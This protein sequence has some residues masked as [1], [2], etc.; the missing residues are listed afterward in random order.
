MRADGDHAGP[1][2]LGE[3]LQRFAGLAVALLGLGVGTA[4][5]LLGSGFAAA[6]LPAGARGRA[7]CACGARRACARGQPPGA[8]PR[9][10][11]PRARRSV[12][13]RAGRVRRRRGSRAPRRAGGRRRRPPRPTLAGSMPPIANKGSVACAAAWRDQLEAGG[14]AALLGRRLPDRPDADVVARPARP[15]RRLDLLGGVGGEADRSRRGRGPRAPPRRRCRPGRRGRRRRRTRRRQVGVVVDD[16]QGAVG[17]GE[18][19]EGAAARSISRLRQLASRAA[20][21]CRRRRRARRAAAARGPR[22]PAAR[23]RR[24]RG[25]R[26]AAARGAAAPM[27]SGGA[28]LMRPRFVLAAS[29]DHRGPRRGY[30][31]APVRRA[32]EYDR[33]NGSPP[34]AERAA[35]APPTV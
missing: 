7:A 6:P 32:T 1:L 16:E 17:V 5:A 31:A 8:P 14:R 23:R 20:G 4:H 22:R 18:P 27:P 13:R 3:R 9:R 11:R 24:S 29:A 10:R 12:R 26:C 15:A 25:A 35:A 2:A 19:P 21:R 30:A 28:R 34:R 33:R